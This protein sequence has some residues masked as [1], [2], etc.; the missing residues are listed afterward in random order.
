MT[1]YATVLLTSSLLEQPG[2]DMSA[3]AIGEIISGMIRTVRNVKSL[4]TL[5]DVLKKLP[6]APTR[7]ANIRELK[8]LFLREN[9]SVLV[10]ICNQC[11]RINQSTTQEGLRGEKH[12]P[13]P[14]H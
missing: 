7:D 1:L 11:H 5:A 10:G 14:H 3:E 6:R 9:G 13:L 8:A 12:T 4:P 2:L